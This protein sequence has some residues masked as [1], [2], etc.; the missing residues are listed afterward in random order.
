M[1]RIGKESVKVNEWRFAALSEAFG[2]SKEIKLAGLEKIYIKRFSDP[3]K[4]LAK[5]N[6]SMSIIGE[7]PRFALEAIIFGGMILVVLYLM[8]QSGVFANAVPILALYAF[9]GY[10]LMLTYNKFIT[11]LLE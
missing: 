7:M 3:A 10:R 9:A 2:A 8:S 11:M 4:I 5:H 1:T 6:S